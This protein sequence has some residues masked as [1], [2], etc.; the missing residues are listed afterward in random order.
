MYQILSPYKCSK[1]FSTNDSKVIERHTL[2]NEIET[3]RKCLCCG[4]EKIIS[5]MTTSSG[6]AYTLAIPP[7]PEFIE[8]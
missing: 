2:I 8:F 5:V 3:I 7:V 1:C 6:G 4:H